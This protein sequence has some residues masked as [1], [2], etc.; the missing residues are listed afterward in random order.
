[1]MVLRD[2]KRLGIYFFYDKDGIADRYIYVFLD[3]FKPYTDKIIIVCNGLLA[4]ESRQTL[5]KY[6]DTIIVR[7][8]KGLD[9]WAYKSALESMGWTAL[10]QYD[11]IIF[12]NNTFMGPVS[13]MSWIFTEM[14]GRNLDFWGITR[15]Y[16][17]DIDPFGYNKDGVLPEHIQ[18]YFL[19]VRRSLLLSPTFQKFWDEFP[20]INSYKESVGMFET[21][22]TEKF[23]KE[24]FL[25][26]TY[27]DTSNYKSLTANPLST[28]PTELLSKQKCPFFK[29]R[30]FF[31]DYEQVL[32]ETAGQQAVLL[33]EYLL[34]SNCFDV[35]L[36]WDNLLRTCHMEDLVRNMGLV[37]ILSED[38]SSH[39][40]T[41]LFGKKIALAMHLYFEDLFDTF[42]CC[43]NKMPLDTDI[44]ITTDTEQKKDI[45]LEKLQ[46]FSNYKINI[47]ITE[48]RG[49]DMSSLWVCLRPFLHDYDYVCFVHD[50]KAGQ[51]KPGSVGESFA[52]K[53]IE[54]TVHSKSFV[55][56]VLETFEKNPRLGILV[57]PGPLHGDYFTKRNSIWTNNFH[58]TVKLAKDLKIS[59]PMSQN[60]NPITAQGNC[61]WFRPHAFSPIFNKDWKYTDFP[62]EPLSPDGTISHALE[63][64]YPFAAQQMG[65]YSG[66]LMS[67]SFARIEYLSLD[68]YTRNCSD[69][70]FLSGG[71]QNY[72]AYVKHLENQVR[73]LYPK[74]SL[75]W[76]LKDRFLRLFN[77]KGKA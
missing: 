6:T 36:V 30:S 15:H 17:V 27:V 48:N 5:E 58:N 9:V 20:F 33:Y 46:H 68:Y 62:Q 59:I 12:A 14:D 16:F 43:V 18:S 70:Y 26:D 54:N 10:T 40:Q 66:I 74:T 52:F 24:G 63:R 22:F 1:M 41:Q 7:E 49:R 11:E 32:T 56:H 67:A 51:T 65:Y 38:M 34:E 35:D 75:K 42:L 29:R 23:S 31:N 21:V 53:C 25:W 60:K 28:Y 37:Y 47:F 45:L 13:P 4:D 69:K 50:K 39:V 77:F 73:E 3:E 2:P 61:L 8:N 57:P 64:I 19:A 76:Q 71:S 72:Q 44:Y 55:Q